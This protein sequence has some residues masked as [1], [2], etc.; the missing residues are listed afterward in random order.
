MCTEMDIQGSLTEVL[1]KTA[2]NWKQSKCPSVGEGYI[3]YDKSMPLNTVQL[4]N[5]E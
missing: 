3:H 2:K 1:S 4:L 5:T